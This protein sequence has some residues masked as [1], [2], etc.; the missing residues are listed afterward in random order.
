MGEGAGSSSL[1]IHPHQI[2]F[3]ALF[4]VIPKNA[5]AG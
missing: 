3:L 4:C 2:S 5:M 1:H